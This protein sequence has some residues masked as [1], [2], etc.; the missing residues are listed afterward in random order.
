MNGLRG[1]G[2]DTTQGHEG[3]KSAGCEEAGKDVAVVEAEVV[4]R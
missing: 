4:R 2:G 3:H 1:G